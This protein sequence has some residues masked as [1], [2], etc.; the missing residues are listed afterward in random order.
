MPALLRLPLLYVDGSSLGSNLGSNGQNNVETILE[1][2][3]HRSIRE[4]VYGQK[5]ESNDASSSSNTSSS[6]VP[7]VATVE[8]IL[9]GEP[10]LLPFR[11]LE[12]QGDDNSVLYAVGYNINDKSSKKKV[13]RYDQED[14]DDGVIIVDDWSDASLS[15]RISGW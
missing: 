9:L 13:S 12:L 1:S 2:V 7:L 5:A 3:V 6:D 8:P 10:I 4:V 11:G 15:T 14:D